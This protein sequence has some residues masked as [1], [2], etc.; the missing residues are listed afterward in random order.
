M[1]TVAQNP[2]EVTNA[3]RRVL[4]GD[5]NAYEVI[6]EYC[7]SQLK[8]YIGSRFGRRGSRFIND[9]AIRTH[10]EAVRRLAEYDPDEGASFQTWLGWLTYNAARKVAADWY[11]PMSEPFDE[12]RH[13]P[14]AGT[15]A[16][17][18]ELYEAKRCSQLLNQEYNA[19][20]KDGR[21]SVALHDEQGLTVRETARRLGMPAIRVRRLLEQKHHRLA[22][23]LRRLGVRPVETDSTPAPMWTRPDT[24]EKDDDWTASVTAVLPDGPDT[25][26][27]AAARDKE[28]EEPDN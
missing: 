12:K 8:S 16:G 7:D 6:Y 9:V 10:A 27:G 22:R 5:V 13:S 24:S 1:G 19:L 11:D 25:L 20:D 28:K 17:P 14:W 26:V 4:A 15:V 2:I 18:A 23:R 21:L 3:I